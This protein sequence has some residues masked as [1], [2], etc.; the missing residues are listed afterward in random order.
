MSHKSLRA[1]ME[2]L[3][4]DPT[5]PRLSVHDIS[6]TSTVRRDHYLLR[7]ACVVEDVQELL[8]AIQEEIT[9]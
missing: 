7:H 6:Y 1:M 4:V 2:E 8:G 9:R 3:F 5:V